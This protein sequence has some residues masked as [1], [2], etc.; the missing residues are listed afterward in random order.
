[1]SAAVLG[2]DTNVLIRFLADDDELQS[3]LAKR[4]LTAPANQP[5]YISALVLAECYTVLTRVKKFPA[6]TVISVFRQMVSSDEFELEQPDIVAMALDDAERAGCGLTD[7]LIGRQ[8]AAAG[9]ATTA[10]FDIRAQRL[11]TMSPVEDRL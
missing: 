4:L 2:I 7:A 11:E 10:T 5:I 8:N 6:D 9:C 3:P 1:M